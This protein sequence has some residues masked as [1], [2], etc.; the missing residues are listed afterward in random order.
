MAGVVII[1]EICI[2][3]ATVDIEAEAVIEVA[4]SSINSLYLAMA[5]RTQIR[6][7]GERRLQRLQ[8]RLILNLF[9]MVLNDLNYIELFK[10]TTHHDIK[11]M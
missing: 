11:H 9:S 6:V 1:V 10:T 2:A 5:L 8:V 4:L 7:I 3:V